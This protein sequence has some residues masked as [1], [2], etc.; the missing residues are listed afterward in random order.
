MKIRLGYVA[1]SK[2]LDNVTTSHT[3]SYTN[4]VNKNEDI[5]K[6]YTQIEKNL[7]DLDKILKFNIKNNI[8]FYRLTSKLIPLATHKDV[9]FDYIEKFK[10]KFKK[11]GKLINDNNL[12][13]DM[14]PDQFAVLNSTKKEVLENTF[15]ILK[16]EYEILDL[17]GIKN[18]VIILHVGS[19]VFGKDA[20]IK[21]FINNFNKLPKYLKESIAIEND[22]KIFNVVDVL[23]I[24]KILNIPMVL[25]YHHHLCNG[26]QDVNI[27]D[28]YAK[29]FKTW[30]KITPKVHFSTPKNKTKKDIRSHHEYINSDD[31]ISFIEEIKIYNHDIDIMIEA[32]GK[33]EALFRLVRNL[34][35]KTNYKFIDDTTFEVN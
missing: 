22:D 5:N 30:T 35:Y 7:L 16:H 9:K 13:I 20:S 33:D 26:A 3:L 34:K 1:I 10:D 32:K 4:F 15:N 24:C 29:I 11:L 21:R 6:I 19:N 18:K 8:H 23:S 12:R 31:F 14:H 2:S 25:D 27:S 28:Y 17:L